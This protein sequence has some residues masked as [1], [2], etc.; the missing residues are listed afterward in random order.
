MTPLPI[1]IGGLLFCIA[2]WAAVGWL[3]EKHRKV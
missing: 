1:F 3:A 2:V